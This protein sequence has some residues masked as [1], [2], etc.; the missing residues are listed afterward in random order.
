LLSVFNVR[1]QT[2]DSINEVLICLKSNNTFG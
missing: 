1:K 2:R